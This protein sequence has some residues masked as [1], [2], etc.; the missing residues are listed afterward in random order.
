[1]DAQMNGRGIVCLRYVDDLLILGRESAHVRKAFAS[2]ER[3]LE[4]L[5]L[6]A[7]D[8]ALRPDKASFGHAAGGVN[9]LGCEL[10]DGVALPSRAKREELLGRVATMLARSE[11]FFADPD[12]REATRL[13][14]SPTLQAVSRALEGFRASY[15]FCEADQAFAS[16][17]RAID[18]RIEKYM[19]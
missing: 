8:P 4:A 5:G 6:R 9:F 15:R 14:L 18:G 3:A 17:E 7:Y 1:F 11:R 19:R 13:G 10:R 12:P 16:L 2:A